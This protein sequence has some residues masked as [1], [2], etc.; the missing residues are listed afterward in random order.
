MAQGG[1]KHASWQSHPRALHDI[2]N[3][4]RLTHPIPQALV[5]LFAVASC[6]VLLPMITI[7]LAVPFYMENA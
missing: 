3:A 7:I 6:T 2:A 1:T 5:Q 4:A